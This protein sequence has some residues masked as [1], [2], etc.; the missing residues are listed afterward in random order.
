MERS[1]RSKNKRIKHFCLVPGSVS[2]RSDWLIVNSYTAFCHRT[3]SPPWGFLCFTPHSGLGAFFLPRRTHRT[4]ACSPPL[5]DCA[6]TNVM[7]SQL[8]AFQTLTTGFYKNGNNRLGASDSATNNSALLPPF[9]SA[10]SAEAAPP[11]FS[12]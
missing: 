10:G 11:S 12:E 1:C 5:T 7:I 4:S 8:A 3:L 2:Q 6:M 9:P